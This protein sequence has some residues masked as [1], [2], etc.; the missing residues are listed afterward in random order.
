[1]AGLSSSTNPIKRVEKPAS[2]VGAKPFTS[3][4]WVPLRTIRIAIQ[5]TGSTGPGQSYH[6]C[7]G[8][9]CLAPRP[10]RANIVMYPRPHFSIQ[11]NIFALHRTI[12][13]IHESPDGILLPL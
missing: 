5:M 1:M 8:L 11:M 4:G 13:G 9:V 2:M 3:G 10:V 12:W 7:H 6:L